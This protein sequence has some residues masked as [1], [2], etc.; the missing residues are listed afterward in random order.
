MI[1]RASRRRSHY[2][3]GL[4]IFLFLVPGLGVYTALMLYPSALSIYYSV[5]DWEGGPVGRAPFVGLDNFREMF[6][7]PVVT[8]ALGNNARLL[9]LSW[10]Y[11]LPVA[12]LLATPRPSWR[13]I[14]AFAGGVMLAWVAL[15]VLDALF[16]GDFFWSWRRST[17]FFERSRG[18][19][20]L[21]RMKKL[22]IAELEQTA[23]VEPG[24]RR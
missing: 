22:N 13:P 14:A 2:G 6:D 20:A 19:K 21:L 5:L 12:L 7:D 18:G 17:Y 15:G 9:F 10:A 1:L 4:G 8:R 3:S 11:Q 24:G 16:V 23:S